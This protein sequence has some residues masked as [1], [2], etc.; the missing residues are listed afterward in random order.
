MRDLKGGF[1]GP[2]QKGIRSVEKSVRYADQPF[3]GVAQ[4][5][6]AEVSEAVM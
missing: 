4:G 3:S 2:P 5:K 6:N 1:G